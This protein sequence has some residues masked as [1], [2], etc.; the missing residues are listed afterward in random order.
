MNIAGNQPS[1]GLASEESSKG[2]YAQSS[3]L[4]MPFKDRKVSRSING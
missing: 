3:K 4:S 2:T 1:S